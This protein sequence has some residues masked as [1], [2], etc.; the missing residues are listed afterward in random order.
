MPK[1]LKC[2][3]KTKKCWQTQKDWEC[4]KKRIA[5]ISEILFFNYENL[6]L[7]KMWNVENAKKAQ[8]MKMQRNSKSC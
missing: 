7:L 6:N 8:Q 3:K 1:L 4:R 5:E 2:W